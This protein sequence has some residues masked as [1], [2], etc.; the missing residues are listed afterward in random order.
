MSG[1]QPFIDAPFSL[2]NALSAEQGREELGRIIHHE[3]RRTA[4]DD[5]GAKPDAVLGWEEVAVGD[6]EAMMREAGAV[7]AAVRREA[8]NSALVIHPGD[9][10]VVGFPDKLTPAMIDRLR[11]RAATRLPGIE[12]VVFDG[13]SHMAVYRAD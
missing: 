7:A 3:R 1:E 8:A 9:K 10:L 12:V 6:R 2:V 13:V 11:E 5:W 4:I